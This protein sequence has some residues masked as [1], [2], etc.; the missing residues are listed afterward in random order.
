MRAPGPAARPSGILRDLEGAAIDAV[1]VAAIR[2]R[3]GVA[4]GRPVATVDR[5]WDARLLGGLDRL[6]DAGGV[7]WGSVRGRYRAHAGRL[8]VT[9]L[10]VDD[11]PLPGSLDLGPIARCAR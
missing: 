6:I 7:G 5:R 11:R 10:R 9:A 1:R 2:S 3:H 8:L 4:G